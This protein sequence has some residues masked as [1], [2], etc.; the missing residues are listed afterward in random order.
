M[1][2]EYTTLIINYIYIYIPAY[3]YYPHDIARGLT[4]Y[5]I[6]TYKKTGYKL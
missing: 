5:K 4:I 6:Y 2:Y 1:N 3:I